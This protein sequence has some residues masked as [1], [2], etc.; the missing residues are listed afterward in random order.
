MAAAAA[1]EAVA[2]AVVRP[3][4]KFNVLSSSGALAAVFLPEII[5]PMLTS[6]GLE[7]V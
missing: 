3:P 2:F 4:G 6:L 1:A 7:F 5:S